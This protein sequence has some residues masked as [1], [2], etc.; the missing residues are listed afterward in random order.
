MRGAAITLLVLAPLS[1]EAQ[2]RSQVD[3]TAPLVAQGFVIAL[4]EGDLGTAVSL[5][6][7]PF[8]FD[9]A[10]VADGPA[11]RA[12][13]ERLVSS[14]RLRGRRVL[15]VQSFAAPEAVRRFGE[16]PGRLRGLVGPR[17]VVALVRL[18]RG[19]IVAFLRKVATFWRVVGV[20]D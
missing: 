20:T 4:F 1:T 10:V 19:G 2:D 18:D 9:G 6:A 5:A 7:P 13:L 17:D 14:G 3:P 16:P 15:R 8:S 11:L 12:E